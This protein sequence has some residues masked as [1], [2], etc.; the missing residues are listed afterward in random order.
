MLI[1][2]ISGYADN[3][4]AFVISAG[5]ALAH[6]AIGATLRTRSSAAGSDESPT[7]VDR[8]LEPHDGGERRRSR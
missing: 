5:R 6:L 1:T 7:D 4:S 2:I 8:E 3:T